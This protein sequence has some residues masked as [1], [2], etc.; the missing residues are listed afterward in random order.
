MF[1]SHWQFR[2]SGAHNYIFAVREQVSER[3]QACRREFRF[4]QYSVSDRIDFF[5]RIGKRLPGVIEE[6]AS[7][8]S[9]INRVRDF[10]GCGIRCASRLHQG[11]NTSFCQIHGCLIEKYASIEV[12]H[13]R[14]FGRIQLVLNQILIFGF[15]QNVFH[16]TLNIDQAHGHTCGAASAVSRSTSV[17]AAALFPL[18]S[19]TCCPSVFTTIQ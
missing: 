11:G 6:N 17:I 1:R 9:V 12:P 15:S 3:E 14:A 7:I 8:A 4:Q 2:C 18:K 16:R 10:N 19:P 13:G 5:M